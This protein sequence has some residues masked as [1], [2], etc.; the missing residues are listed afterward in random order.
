[1][2]KPVR[3][4]APSPVNL[5]DSATRQDVCYE[6]PPTRTWWGEYHLAQPGG[7]RGQKCV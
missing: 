2:T 6:D 5:G 3:D 1:M 4:R 7:P